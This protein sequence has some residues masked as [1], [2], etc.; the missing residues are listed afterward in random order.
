MLGL[1]NT[2]VFNSL[3]LPVVRH[4]I[5]WVAGA[6]VLLGAEQDTVTAISGGL[7]GLANLGWWYITK[8]STPALQ[9]AKEA[10]KIL[11]GEKK[12]ATV[13]TPDNVPNIQV[14]AKSL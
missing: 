2:V 12:S 7:L 5:G 14:S 11:G 9:V 4:G 10:D 1:D 13:A 3:I 6:L 8:P